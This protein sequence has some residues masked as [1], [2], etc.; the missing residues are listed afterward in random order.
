MSQAT[1]PFSIPPQLP[2]EILFE[3]FT[4]A[5]TD[6]GRT[7]SSLSVVSRHFREASK[8]FRFQSVAITGLDS[9]WRFLLL[10]REIP[11]KQRRVVFLRIEEAA[12]GEHGFRMAYQRQHTFNPVLEEVFRLIAPSLKVLHIRQISLDLGSLASWNLPQLTEL[13]IRECTKVGRSVPITLP[14]LQYL[15]LWEPSVEIWRN[16][17]LLPKSITHI[18]VTTAHVDRLYEALAQASDDSPKFFASKKIYLRP[19]LDSA[20]TIRRLSSTTSWLTVLPTVYPPA[21]KTAAMIWER[22]LSG[23]ALW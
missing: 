20:S 4:L 18:C 9:L 3:I 13:T 21:K 5:C 19:I 16:T 17:S 14:R 10:I 11:S 23:S 7:G 1:M 6:D 22:R 12:E 15:D 8:G 2:L